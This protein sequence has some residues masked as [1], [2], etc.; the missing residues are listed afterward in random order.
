MNLVNNRNQRGIVM[1]ALS[2]RSLLLGVTVLLG[3]S[4]CRGADNTVE[5]LNVSYDPTRELYRKLNRTFAEHYRAE[6]GQ[7]VRIRQSHGGS[8]AQARAVIDG[9]PADIV[10]L[11]VWADT[12]A[13]RKKGMIKDKWEERFPN[14]SLP[15]YS[16]IVLVVRK[17]NPKG[18]HDWE[19]LAKPGVQVIPS[20]PK[21]GGGARVNFL[22]MWGAMRRKGMSEAKVM[23]FL[24]HVYANVPVL[25]SGARAATITFARR[26]IGD[27][28]VGWE[29]EARLELA[30]LGDEVEIV[31]P[32]VSIYAEP[33][34]AIV[35]EN[36]DR[37]GT[38]DAAEA[39]L[40]YLYTDEAQ[41][42][43]AENFYRPTNPAVAKRY[44]DKF[45]AIELM[46]IQE[47][48]PGGW[49][50]AQKRFFADGGIFDQIYQTQP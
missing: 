46:R 5:L 43:I 26:N 45:P 8:G 40:K 44:S 37:K 34:V 13:I 18:I 38:R 33:Y 1:S 22:A 4:G 28:Q 47:I 30:E 19:D 39:Y 16:T 14:R 35:D 27:V 12:D 50:E 25:D 3:L 15:Y 21:T 17:G 9:L 36:V 31:Y 24:T 6:T 49:G 23:E 11:C 42:I 7:N 29:N 48:V 2:R 41:V 32:T 20:N 10:T